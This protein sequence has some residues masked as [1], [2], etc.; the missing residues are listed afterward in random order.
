[1]SITFNLNNTTQ[2]ALDAAI[3][4]CVR[5]AVEFLAEKHGFDCEESL[6]EMNLVKPVITKKPAKAKVLKPTIPLPFCGTLLTSCCG[7]RVNHGLH[8][9][10]SN[11]KESSETSGE[12]LDYCKTCNKQAMSNES[13]A[14]NG[15]DIRARISGEWSPVKG[16]LVSYGNVMEKLNITR[17]KAETEA[18]KLGLTIPEE[19]FEVV[20]GRRGRPKSD[21]SISS[22]D[23][24]KPK[25]PRGR[26]KKDK[27]VLNSST[28]DDLISQR[29]AAASA[30]TTES[31]SSSESEASPSTTKIDRSAAREEAKAAKLAEREEANASKLAER[32]ATKAAKLAEREAAKAAKLAERE[33]A[34][35]AKLAEKKAKKPAT[36]SNP[37]MFLANLGTP[38][39]PKCEIHDISLKSNVDELTEV[40]NSALN[41]GVIDSDIELEAEDSDSG[42]DEE[43]SI[44]AI[45]KEIKGKKYVMA[46]DTKHL[47][48]A[49]SHEPLNQYYDEEADEI[50][51]LPDDEE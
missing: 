3:L 43:E 16:K 32:E 33:A 25:K 11:A 13:G 15:G 20:K 17:E 50:K 9:Q 19:Q 24:E 44:D 26:P 40:E 45:I 46:R 41:S 6:A 29:V 8:S 34:K 38:S 1:M 37:E 22:S 47:Y 36:P 48:D 31:C 2:R 39:S 28:G 30:D 18:A 7:I 49:E 12:A 10:C 35:A 23:D 42:S 4:G 14:P 51:N 21:T 27:K 5:E